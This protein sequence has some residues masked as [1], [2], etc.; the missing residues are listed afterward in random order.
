MIACPY[1]TEI[2]SKLFDHIEHGFIPNFKRISM[3]KKYDI[4]IYGYEPNNPEMK[5]NK[6]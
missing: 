5:K 1:F 3:Q 2:R 4:L 6:W